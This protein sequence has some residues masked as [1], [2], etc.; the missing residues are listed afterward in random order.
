MTKLTIDDLLSKSVEE[1]MT[2]FKEVPLVAPSDS[3][4]DFDKHDINMI[5]DKLGGYFKGKEHLI[6]IGQKIKLQD[7]FLIVSGIPAT[8]NRVK[9]KVI[10]PE[11]TKPISK[12]FSVQRAHLLGKSVLFLYKH[13]DKVMIEG[14]EYEVVQLN[15]ASNGLFVKVE[16]G[17]KY[18]N[19]TKIQM[20]K[21]TF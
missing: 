6:S 2:Y 11:T 14:V 10:D 16:G 20:K 4:Q 15:P 18:F 21:E 1:I 12:E 17:K 19:C 8:S 7:I 3:N 5:K 9:F 13:G